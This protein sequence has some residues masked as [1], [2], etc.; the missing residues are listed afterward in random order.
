MDILR[1]NFGRYFQSKPQRILKGW[2]LIAFMSINIYWT[3]KENIEGEMDKNSNWQMLYQMDFSKPVML[4]GGI[5]P[6]DAKAV[7]KLY[8]DG[9][10]EGVD[11]NSGFEDKA[12]NLKTKNKQ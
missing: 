8:Q 10:I 4:S 1:L 7:V 9:V 3:P 12:R 5:G 6:E 2:R 11:V